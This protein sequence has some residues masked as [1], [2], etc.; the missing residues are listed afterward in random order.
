TGWRWTLRPPTAPGWPTIYRPAARRA[1]P[2][3]QDLDV[4]VRS[5]H[6]D[7]LPIPDQPGGM[8]YPDDGR[9]AV[10]PSDHRAMCHQAPHLCHQALDRDEQ[11]RPTGVRVGSN[12]DVAWL[13]IGLR[14][15]QDDARPPFDSSS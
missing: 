14:H 3:G 12:Q 9:N 10:L 6:A 2:L 4:A 1:G 15:V 8:L 7:P 13:E 11:W 5:V